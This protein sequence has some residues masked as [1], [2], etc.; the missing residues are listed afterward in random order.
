MS[1][2][3][4]LA[5]VALTLLSACS[6][7]QEEEPGY[8][9]ISY[10]LRQLLNETDYIVEGTIASYETD[11]KIAVL[12]F[13]KTL[14]GQSPTPEA[15]LDFTTGI[16]VATT[17]VQR[18]LVPGAPL[19]W[20]SNGSV[21][22]A[23]LNRFFMMF[24][25]NSASSEG[26]WIYSQVYVGMN[27]TFNGSLPEFALLIR[28]ILSGNTP[29]P[30]PDPALKAI[31]A[32]DLR[33]LPIWGEPVDEEYLPRCFRKGKPASLDLRRA[34]TPAGLVAGLGT[35]LFQGPWGDA[36]NFDAL[37]PLEKG[38]AESL[39]VAGFP[40]T[41]SLRVKFQGYLDIPKDGVY[42]FTLAGD[43][44]STVTLSLGMTPVVSLSGGSA[45]ECGGEIPLKAGKHAFRLICAAREGERKFQVFWAGPGFARQLIP[46]N[47]L[48][49]EP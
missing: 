7:K 29:A 17:S 33:A 3:G 44:Q 14:R 28:D 37:E 9:E 4:V 13:H 41:E 39:T 22:A 10:P 8:D 35:T 1:E 5:L 21:A 6:K 32:A 25:S 23:Y 43:A 2:P 40:K 19:L 46:A 49:R 27:K 16:P 30:E 42:V 36:R 11:S 48:F 18:H 38:V 34:E 12:K 24:Y 15:R 45:K 26:K 20:F 47:A 31:T